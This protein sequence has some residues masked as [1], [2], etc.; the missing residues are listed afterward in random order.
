M[1]GRLRGGQTVEVLADSGLLQTAQCAL[2]GSVGREMGA[3]RESN[4]YGS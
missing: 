1:G 3:R 4:L 2:E